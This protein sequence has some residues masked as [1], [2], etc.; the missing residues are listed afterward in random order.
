MRPNLRT[1]VKAGTAVFR[2]DRIL[3]LHRSPEAS[4]P[5]LWDLPGGHVEIGESLPRAAQRE[6]R[7]ET[8]LSV[9][10]EN[11]F[12]VELVHAI[13]KRGKPRVEVGVYFHCDAPASREPTI[14]PSEHVDYAWVK[15][16]ELA[17]YPTLPH[18]SQTVQA[19]F[20]TR[21]TSRS[22]RRGTSMRRSPPLILNSLNAGVPAETS[23][24]VP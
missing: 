10:I 9:R 3:L 22:P 24:M 2:G 11:L 20:L 16:S 23:S 1:R 17:A 8:G 21:P 18:L 19:A 5:D 7:E 13:T 6:T 4:N 15:R 14:D 12:H